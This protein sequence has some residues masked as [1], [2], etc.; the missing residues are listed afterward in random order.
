MVVY[1]GI[2][3]EICI[4]GGHFWGGGPQFEAKIIDEKYKL[5]I[6]IYQLSKHTANHMKD[7]K[8]DILT[9]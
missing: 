2:Y 4:K 6:H 9:G 7:K 3:I 5:W 8:I 1:I